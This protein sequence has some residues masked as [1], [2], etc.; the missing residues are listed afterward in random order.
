MPSTVDEAIV[1]ANRFNNSLRSAAYRVEAFG[2]DA[3]AEYDRLFPRLDIDVS[4]SRGTDV[5]TFGGISEDTR[6]LLRL[7]WD[8]PTG[9]E[10]FARRDRASNL[11]LA[12]AER[13]HERQRETEQRVRISY[14]DVQ[15]STERLVPLKDRVA[16]SDAVVDAYQKQFEAGRRTLL[17]TLDAE[18]ERFLAKVAYNDGEYEN[19]RAR[20]RLFSAAGRLREALGVTR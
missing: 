8:F 6:A 12:A 1:D 18:N 11:R 16:A 4:Q 13:M 14:S 20:Y 19:L 10:K 3:D 2:H 7:S 5:E 15:K 9:G 17:D